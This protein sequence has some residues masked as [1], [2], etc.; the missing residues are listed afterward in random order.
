M[1]KACFLV[2][3]ALGGMVAR[4]SPGGAPVKPVA[5]PSAIEMKATN[6]VAQ[7]AKE[8]YTRA[9]RDFDQTMKKVLPPKKLA[10]VWKSVI[11]KLG[12]FKKQAGTR[13]ERAG[14]HE[15]VFVS[16]VFASGPLDVKVVFT[17]AGE[18]T[19]FFFV[20]S[21]PPVKY[22]APDYVNRKAFRGVL[23]ARVQMLIR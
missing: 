18:I 10:E 6:L 19:G 7:L 11:D 12:A 17:G 5:T 22:L 2:A 20:E 13:L 4:P 3:L 1:N 23:A 9:S 21:K 15:F 16:C 8:D 14:K